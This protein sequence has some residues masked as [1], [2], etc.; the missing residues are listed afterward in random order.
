[1][2]MAA[3]QELGPFFQQT[4]KTSILCQLT[5]YVLNCF[6]KN[7]IFIRI[8]IIKRRWSW[9][10]LIFMIGIHVLV[11]ICLNT[12]IA[13]GPLMTWQ[14]KEPGY[15][16]QLYWPG[17]STPKGLMSLWNLNQVFVNID[18]KYL[19]SGMSFLRPCQSETMFRK[20]FH[21][22][23]SKHFG[24]QYTPNHFCHFHEIYGTLS[25]LFAGAA[26]SHYVKPVVAYH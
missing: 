15:Q 2:L 25:S 21:T 11:T 13:L 12:E 22:S 7:D 14:Y 1:M 9:D 20:L 3:V 16:Q 26:P 17:T 18:P 4:L 19:W 10:R 23:V 5:L 8:P 24:V 6:E